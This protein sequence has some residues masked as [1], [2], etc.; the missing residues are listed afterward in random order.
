MSNDEN[1]LHEENGIDD[2]AREKKLAINKDAPLTEVESFSGQ[3]Y[4]LLKSLRHLSTYRSYSVYLVTAWIVGFFLVIFDKYFELFLRDILLDYVLVGVVLTILIFTEMICRF[5][6]GYIGDNYN[7]KIL[8]VGVVLTRSIG[9]IAF[10]LSTDIVMVIIAAMIFGSAALFTSGSSAYLYENTPAEESGLA[11]A[12]LQS[13]GGLGL[14]GLG[15]IIW[16]LSLGNSFL[17]AIRMMFLVGGISYAIAAVIRAAF[18]QPPD[19]LERETSSSNRFSDFITQNTLAAK[20]FVSNMFV[21][22]IV[23]VVDAI[24]DG[25]FRYVNMFY[26]NEALSFTYGEIS[27]MLIVVLVV[28]I[29]LSIKVGSYFDQRGGKRAVLAVYSVMPISLTLLILA[30]IFPYWLPTQSVSIISMSY[31]ILEPLLSTAFLSIAIKGVNDILWWTLILALLRRT[32]PKG[33]TAKVISIVFIMLNLVG[34]FIPIPSGLIYSNFGALP[35]LLGSLL[36]N[37]IILIILIRVNI[38]DSVSKE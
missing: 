18:L 27:L 4:N 13:S 14:I 7:R 17:E 29:P 11:M 35:L 6:G 15:S 5:M 16:L 10:A 24:S 38:E 34:I 22:F 1:S 9:M 37:F 26:L 12:L 19:K 23:L 2:I 3:D 32:I 20:L 21:F 8:S 36:A 30:P 31:P 25:M 28:S 33:E